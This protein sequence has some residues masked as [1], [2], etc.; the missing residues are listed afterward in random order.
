MNYSSYPSGQR[1]SIGNR[2]SPYL[3]SNG[4]GYTFFAAGG[5]SH[6]YA[7]I[8]AGGGGEGFL[9]R[10]LT[11]GGDIG[12]FDFP[13]DRS[14]GYGVMT[15]NLGWH[16]VDRSKPKKLD[17]YLGLTVLGGA[18]GSCEFQAAGHLTGG[19]NYW[20]K[21]RLGM[22]VGAVLQVVGEEPIMAARVGLTFR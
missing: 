21:D 5:C 6:G 12:Y 15:L 4:Y 20:F 18:L 13:A 3:T 19:V 7:N 22:Q 14:S 11:L 17:P 9:W 2:I 1:R 10:G 16:F 8:G